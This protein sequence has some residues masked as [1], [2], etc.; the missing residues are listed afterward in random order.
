MKE[1]EVDQFIR[2]QMKLKIALKA[3]FTS[4]ESFLIRNNRSFL[5][6]KETLKEAKDSSSSDDLKNLLFRLDTPHPYLVSLL[7]ETKDKCDNV[8]D[9]GGSL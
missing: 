9:P 3:I 5:L 4:V 8:I 2:S 1:L 6:N 7:M